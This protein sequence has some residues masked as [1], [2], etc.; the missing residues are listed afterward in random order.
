MAAIS[1]IWGWDFRNIRFCNTTY[2]TLIP[3]ME[4]AVHSTDFRS[5]NLIHSFAKLLTKNLANRLASKLDDMAS[6]NQSAFVNG[7]FIQ[8]S[9]LLV[10]QTT[11]YIHA[12][13]QPRILLKFDISKAFDSV[14]WSFL[15]DMLEKLGFG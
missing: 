1:A 6:N 4:G 8:D 15:M 12:Q 3:K 14:S 11:C 5:I 7:R 2:I 9:F 10:Q 13:K